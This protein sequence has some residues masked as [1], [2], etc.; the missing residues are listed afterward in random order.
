MLRAWCQLLPTHS[1]QAPGKKRGRR[2][3]D[4]GRRPGQEVSRDQ[5]L[6]PGFLCLVPARPHSLSW[7]TPGI[8]A[9]A[10]AQGGFQGNRGTGLGQGL[11]QGGVRSTVLTKA[12]RW[13][14]C[15]PG[16]KTGSARP[17]GG[18]WGGVGTVHGSVGGVLFAWVAWQ[19]PGD[20]RTLAA[21]RACLGGGTHQQWKHKNILPAGLL[22]PWD[23]GPA[24]DG[25]R[26]RAGPTAPLGTP[27][28]A[29]SLLGQ[30]P[31]VSQ[32]WT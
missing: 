21:V 10:S 18:V 27:G 16:N 3:K 6:G 19:P 31:Q 23:L 2:W 15:S 32:S 30:C 25:G 22:G 29:W 11:S 20:W 5:T 9:P 26:G 24:G 8:E 1:G 12:S 14:W 7:T 28:E 17:A 13:P 4:R